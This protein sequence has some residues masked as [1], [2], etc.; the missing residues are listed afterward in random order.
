[1]VFLAA[2]YRYIASLGMEGLKKNM[3]IGMLYHQ[4]I[5]LG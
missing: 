2:K 3:N 5:K 4:Y 1:M